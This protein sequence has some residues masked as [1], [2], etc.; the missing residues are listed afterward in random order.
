MANEFGN[1]NGFDSDKNDNKVGNP[2]LGGLG[3]LHR[4]LYIHPPLHLDDATLNDIVFNFSLQEFSTRVGFICGLEQGGKFTSEQALSK[5]LQLWTE[6][7]DMRRSFYPMKE[8]KTMDESPTAVDTT[9]RDNDA[10]SAKPGPTSSEVL[11]PDEAEIA[12]I[13]YSFSFRVSIVSSLV[14]GGRIRPLEGYK[15]I[16]KH[17]KELR[18]KLGVA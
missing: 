1:L 13:F 8:R 4:F 16:N 14:A 17:W 5:I 18:Q 9:M 10:V 7:K 3:A 11:T 2:E 6:L 15:I 12:K